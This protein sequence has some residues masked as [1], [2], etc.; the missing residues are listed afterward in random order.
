M[1]I[2]ETLRHLDNEITATKAA[3]ARAKEVETSL[4]DVRDH[5][6]EVAEE[7]R[8][9]AHFIQQ[10]DDQS[11]QTHALISVTEEKNQ[12]AFKSC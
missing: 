5:A 9:V 7:V 3:V 12:G 10:L 6:D 8:R 1:T 11:G 4:Q 2:Q